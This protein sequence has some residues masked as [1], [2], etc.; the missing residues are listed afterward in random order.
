MGAPADPAEIAKARTLWETT[1]RPV[2]S[3]CRQVDRSAPWL[4]R[5]ARAGRWKARPRSTPASIRG[6]AP[7]R[8]RFGTAWAQA[9]RQDVTHSE[10]EAYG[11][12]LEDYR[13]LARLGFVIF[14]E[15]NCFRCDNA[16]VTSEQ[17]RQK[18]DRE[19]RLRKV[20]AQNGVNP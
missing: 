11:E 18:A 15:G 8:G 1:D 10:I 6:K 20:T 3:I 12:S 9:Q 19:R 17:L 13:F 4:Y 14:I 5:Q 2:E 7:R 16:L